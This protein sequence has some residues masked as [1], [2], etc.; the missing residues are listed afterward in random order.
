MLSA[1]YMRFVNDACTRED[2]RKRFGVLAVNRM[3]FLISQTSNDRRL[4]H[5]TRRKYDDETNV[6][7]FSLR[8]LHRPRETEKELIDAIHHD[9]G[10]GAK[11][12]GIQALGAVSVFGWCMVTGFALFSVIKRGFQITSNSI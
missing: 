4:A 6:H 3:R 1:W 12:L 9:L 5:G 11:L 2:R 10:G 7:T 8:T